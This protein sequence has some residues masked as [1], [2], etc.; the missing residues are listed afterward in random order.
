M[1]W[2]MSRAL[3]A[4]W[5]KE[6]CAA[7]VGEEVRSGE[8]VGAG[9]AVEVEVRNSFFVGDD[10][11]AGKSPWGC[12]RVETIFT[13]QRSRSYI[14]GAKCA[15]AMARGGV[16]CRRVATVTELEGTH[17]GLPFPEEAAN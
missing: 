13:M 8:L 15:H 9:D 7:A 11:K 4:A 3:L 16:C 17:P 12:L 1:D 14:A 10:S 5:R 2:A 6:L